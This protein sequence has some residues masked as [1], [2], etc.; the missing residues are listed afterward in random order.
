MSS[1]DSASSAEIPFCA[2]PRPPRPPA[3]ALPPKACDTHA[4]V[5]GPAAQFPYAADRSYTPPDAP[6]AKYLAMLDTLGFARG[7]LVQGSAHGADN[8][9][10]L[11][12]LA[13]TS[14]RLRGVAVADEHVPPAELRRW[15][16]LG[17][18]GLRF[19]HF[20][21]DGQLH[22]R[23]GVPLAAARVLAPVMRE[24]GWHLQ[25]WIDVKDL[26]DTV[27]VLHELGLPVVIDHMGRTPAAAGVATA[28]F[29]SL[30]RLLGA[31]GCWVKVSGA[32]R[33]SRLPPD[34]PDARPFMQALVAENPERLLW[35]GDW[36]H[37]RMDD[38]MPEVGHL[39]D[40]FQ[41]WTPDAAVRR[42]ILVA[43]PARLYGFPEA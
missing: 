33:I 22:Y 7:V 3:I 21:Q 14:A 32:H 31:G 10:M 23:G 20:F 9:A 36:P 28:G 12:A 30:L 13:R 5:F 39:L 26:P 42:R 6:L 37:P 38:E 4:H 29:Q 15:H 16:A 35:G 17:V 34:Y 1:S 8:S 25:L 41:Q 43:N 40:L 18:R 24:L 2:A 19:N 11:D 27:P